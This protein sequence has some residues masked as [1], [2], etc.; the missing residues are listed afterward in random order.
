MLL[1]VGRG[2]SKWHIRTCP[3]LLPLPQR[4]AEK[5]KK[6]KQQE[7]EVWI[8]ICVLHSDR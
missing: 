5:K 1:L 7:L 4:Q 8:P 2:L 6:N 3:L